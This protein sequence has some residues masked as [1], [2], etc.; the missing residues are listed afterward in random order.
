M[1]FDMFYTLCHERPPRPWQSALAR[2]VRDTGEWPDSL[3]ARTGAGKTTVIDIALWN[4]IHD[5]MTNGTENRS[6]P[7]RIVLTVERKL[8]IDEA[9]DYASKIVKKIDTVRGLEQARDALRSLLPHGLRDNDDEPTVNLVSMHSDSV[10]DKTWWRRPF[11]C[12][13]LTGTMTQVVSRILFRGVGESAGVAS[14]SAGALGTD[15]IRFCDEPH[16]MINAVHAMREQ[17]DLVTHRKPS[18]VVLGATVPK[19]MR[20]G[21]V[22]RASDYGDGVSERTPRPLEVQFT[23][24]ASDM[25]KVIA[26]TAVMEHKECGG[27]VVVMVSTTDTARSVAKNIKGVDVSVLTSQMR[28]YDRKGFGE[29]PSRDRIIVATQTLEVGVDFDA[30]VIVSDIAPLPSIIQRAGRAGRTGRDAKVHVVSVRNTMKD[31]KREL[32]LSGHKAVYGEGVLLATNDVLA[33]GIDSLD[34]IDI[35]DDSYSDTWI[36]EPRRVKL[37]EGMADLLSNTRAQAPWSAYL[38]GP[39][40]EEAVNVRV[41]WR[42]NPELV[43]QIIPVN[44]ECLNLPYYVLLKAVSAEGDSKSKNKHDYSDIDGDSGAEFNTAGH[45]AKDGVYIYD[46][47][48]DNPVRPV[49]RVREIKPGDTVVLHSDLGMYT[50]DSGWNPARYVPVNDLSPV[51]RDEVKFNGRGER[52]VPSQVCFTKSQIAQMVEDEDPDDVPDPYEWYEFPYLLIECREIRVDGDDDKDVNL[53]ADHLVQVGH[54]ASDFATAAGSLWDPGIFYQAGIH[55]DLGKLVTSFQVLKLGNTGPE[56][57]AKSSVHSSYNPL[58]QQGIETLPVPWR[59]ESGIASVLYDAGMTETAYLVADHHGHGT[60]HR[61]GEESVRYVCD[62][63]DGYSPWDL[64]A[65]SLIFRY[66]DWYASAHPESFGLSFSELQDELVPGSTF[67]MNLLEPKRLSPHDDVRVQRLEGLTLCESSDRLAAFGCYAAVL[68]KDPDALIQF[69]NGVPEIASNSEI[70]WSLPKVYD[71]LVIVKDHKIK[72]F[73]MD[74]NGDEVITEGILQDYWPVAYKDGKPVHKVATCLIPNSGNTIRWVQSVTAED[75][76]KVL[77]D[78]RYGLSSDAKGA[79]FGYSQD[80]L[81]DKRFAPMN[82]GAV[83][84]WIA[85]YQVA[86]GAPQSMFGPGVQDYGGVTV[87]CIPAYNNVWMNW[88]GLQFAAR[89]GYGWLYE[90]KPIDKQSCWEPLW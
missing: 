9:H 35:E 74:D 8:I 51:T 14:M 90:K 60:V 76:I 52:L 72:S 55:H 20:S 4:L 29:I 85:R 28:P 47:A 19:S 18:T 39:D 50:T 65:A 34:N 82:R 37:D 75:C 26:R 86:L 11:G 41:L 21:T 24:S 17:G 80:H 13:I 10:W 81:E 48:L 77:H 38:R 57:W 31:G 2:R 22:F 56:P 46:P 7:L 87:L 64:A 66:A 5:V 16:L 43:S 83:Y 44:S 89:H 61:M 32:K 6:A 67:E 54:T 25:A 68:E 40:Y 12:T 23:E 27:E 42:D 49:T 79:G 15:A 58:L 1:D 59:H 71:G 36:P 63:P 70:E 45:L 62:K 69:D 30:K 78:K 53:L 3:I 33:E 73:P 88:N 84:A